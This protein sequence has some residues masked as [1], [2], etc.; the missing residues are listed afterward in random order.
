MSYA[1]ENTHSMC[2]NSRTLE[3]IKSEHS[4]HFALKD[5]ERKLFVIRHYFPRSCQLSFSR[6]NSWCE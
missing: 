3:R 6:F 2:A 4:T 1:D 5:K